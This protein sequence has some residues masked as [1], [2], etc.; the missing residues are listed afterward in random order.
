MINDNEEKICAYCKSPVL[1]DENYIKIG[2][3]YFHYNKE[4]KL[5]NCYFPEEEE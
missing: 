5:E 2:Q 3:Q 1:P 4:N